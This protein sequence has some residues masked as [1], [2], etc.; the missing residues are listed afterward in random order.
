M[1]MQ[2]PHQPTPAEG[3]RRERKKDE[4]RERIARVALRL[5]FERGF[6]AT[7]VDEIS[8][9]ADVAKGTFF[10]YFPRKEAVLAQFAAMEL[11]RLDAIVDEALAAGGSAREC[12]THVF[13]RSTESY[14]RQPE[15]WRVA[16]LELLKG[17]Q[18]ELVEA[19]DRAHASVRRLVDLAQQRGEL[20][21]DA[22]ADRITELLRGVFQGTTLV[23][24][25]GPTLFDLRAEI[26]ARLA[27]VFDGVATEA[28]R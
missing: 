23:W 14:E 19:Q 20:R 15:L 5:F 8:H 12:I 26:R 13:E 27:L 6:A 16:F 1:A 25:H 3:S 28:S 18:A 11:D 4:T 7:T 22:D 17:P 24:L 2:E 21:G 10:N 9:V